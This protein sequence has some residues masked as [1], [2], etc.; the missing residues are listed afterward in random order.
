MPQSTALVSTE[1]EK[2]RDE[3]GAGNQ[4]PALLLLLTEGSTAGI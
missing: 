4:V 3:A 2:G 1:G